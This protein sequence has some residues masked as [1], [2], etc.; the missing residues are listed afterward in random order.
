MEP[1]GLIEQ[2]TR[3]RSRRDDDGIY[4]SKTS[5]VLV[6]TIRPTEDH[7]CLGLTQS[8]LPIAK[9]QLEPPIKVFVADRALK[10]TATASAMTAFSVCVYQKT[11]GRGDSPD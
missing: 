4:Q 6:L 11:L 2:Q 5:V 7:H 8:W 9:A 1:E 10:S 3:S